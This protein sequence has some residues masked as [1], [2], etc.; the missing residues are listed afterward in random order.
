M[1]GF[2]QLGAAAREK[3]GT[4]SRAEGAIHVSGMVTAVATGPQALTRTREQPATRQWH[5]KISPTRRGYEGN[6]SDCET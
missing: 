3:Y 1:H 6:R 5:H 4:T 2:N